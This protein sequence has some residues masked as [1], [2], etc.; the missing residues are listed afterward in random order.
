MFH[1]VV[2]ELK[3]KLILEWKGCIAEG[4]VKGLR[5]RV[6]IYMALCDDQHRDDIYSSIQLVL[7]YHGDHFSKLAST[8]NFESSQHDRKLFHEA[9]CAVRHVA[10][11]YG[12]SFPEMLR[13]PQFKNMQDLLHI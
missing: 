6:G 5:M 7:G 1:T 2:G 12:G 10:S 8:Q 13:A 9:A 4:V 11:S 3:E